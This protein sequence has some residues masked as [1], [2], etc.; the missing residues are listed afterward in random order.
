MGLP[1]SG[2][3]KSVEGRR[4]DNRCFAVGPFLPTVPINTRTHLPY[5]FRFIGGR[6]R[7]AKLLRY[8][9]PKN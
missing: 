4:I 1:N 8:I 9:C 7:R 3:L 2:P 5:V 6:A